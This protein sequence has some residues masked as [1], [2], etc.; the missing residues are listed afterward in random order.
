MDS[1]VREP[2]Y[3][4]LTTRLRQLVR[5]GEF[6]PGSQFL[7]ERQI[8]ERFGVSRSTANQSLAS[9]VSEGQ[10]DFRKGVGTF[11]RE[12]RLDYDLRSLVSFTDK[13]RASGAAPSTRVLAFSR[14]E[15]RAEGVD[16]PAPPEA[17]ASAVVRRTTARCTST[18]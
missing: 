13:A 2:I 9:L 8:A 3:Q 4:Q 16:D 12:S 11:V 7:T 1:L 18:T 10:L 5:S 6:P 17:R 14:I 15:A